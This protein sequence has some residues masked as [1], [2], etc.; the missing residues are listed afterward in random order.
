[1][2]QCKNVILKNMNVQQR[3]KG[4]AILIIIAIIAV[5]GIGYLL[6]SSSLL[7]TNKT[8]ELSNKDNNILQTACKNA[9][10]DYPEWTKASTDLIIW[11]N[12][13]KSFNFRNSPEDKSSRITSPIKPPDIL[14][15]MDF[16][17]EN[18]ITYVT[19][20]NGWKI[21][22]L[23]LNGLN[24]PDNTKIYE[25]AESV[26]YIN[27][28]PVNKS[29]FIV[30]SVSGGKAYSKYLN[31]VNSEEKILLE[32]TVK[33][34]ADLKLAVSPKGTS[35]YLLS[36]EKLKVFEIA[37][38]KE[39]DE[40]DS[41]K[42][43]V[44]IGNAYILY[45]NSDGAFVYNLKTK[46]KSKLDKIGSVSTLT[47][48]PKDGGVIAF[49]EQ[50]NTKIVNCQTWQII[51]TRQGAELKTLTSEK[52]AIT[53]KGDSFGYW[54]VMDA[55]WDVKILEEKSKFVTVWQRY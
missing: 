39:S 15:D 27:I 44:W 51:N 16:V 32:T 45:S 47:F 28:S 49:N 33:N 23:K 3:Q 9:I 54:R 6:L 40:I 7:K 46:E 4:V 34:T 43:A 26:S 30:F 29:G 38:K 17:G 14:A 52:T 42:S 18:E 25:K 24:P 1:M 35:V 48:N 19:T 20:G 41:V 37:S 5:V 8:S 10:N 21:S 13:D 12:P 55:D 2:Q 22:T 36:D 53:I 11:E 50:G 31:T